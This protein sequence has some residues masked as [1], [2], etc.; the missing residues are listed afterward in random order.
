MSS[1]PRINYVQGTAAV[2]GDSQDLTAYEQ[3]EE[4][5]PKRELFVRTPVKKPR[6]IIL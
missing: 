2:A 1:L 4:K 6:P 3:I 5:Q